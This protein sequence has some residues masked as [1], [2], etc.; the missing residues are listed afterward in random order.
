MRLWREGKVQLW[1]LEERPRS[2]FAVVDE[3][4]VRIEDFHLPEQGERRAHIKYSTLFLA[5]SLNREF[6]ELKGQATPQLPA[7][8]VLD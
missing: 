1:R 8:G 5:R 3:K 2:H 6:T 7:E 4:H